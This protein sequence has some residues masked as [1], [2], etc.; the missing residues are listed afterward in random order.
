MPGRLARRSVKRLGPG[1]LAAEILLPAEEVP[2][3]LTGAARRARG[4]GVHLDAEVYHL[5]GDQA[6]VLAAY[7]VDH[8][9]G[10]FVGGGRVPS[11]RW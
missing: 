1:L 3:F 7:L 2:G 4:A 8:R 9:R 5:R 10:T 11:M 6:L